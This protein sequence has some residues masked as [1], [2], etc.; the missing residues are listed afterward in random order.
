MILYRNETLHKHTII[1]HKKYMDYNNLV[2][3]AEIF[4]G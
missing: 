3:T 4:A 2:Q 1:S